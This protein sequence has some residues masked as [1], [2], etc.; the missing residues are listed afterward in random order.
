ML[1]SPQLTNVSE[2][3]RELMD[4]LGGDPDELLQL[5]TDW[6]TDAGELLQFLTDFMDQ[7][8]LVVEEDELRAMV[9]R[10]V[11]E[12]YVRELVVLGYDQPTIV[13]LAL[14]NATY[15]ELPISN[16]E[17]LNVVKAVYW[18]RLAEEAD[19]PE[20]TDVDRLRLAFEALDASGIIARENFTCCQ[21]CGFAEIGDEV[22]EDTRP[23]GFV[24][25]HQQDT[26]A[27]ACGGGLYLSYGVFDEFDSERV[28][29]IG[30]H[31]VR[32]LA[33]Q[34][35]DV[36]WDGSVMHRILVRLDWQARVSAL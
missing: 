32:A 22:P 27:A 36:E 3:L 12:A 25:F 28:T 7:N 21:T 26:Y 29:A 30:E 6:G 23:D 17:T 18:E 31:V 16:D 34:G 4:E 15:E 14:D 35:L 10:S 19:W 2:H 20:V 24:F 33:G 9:V 8:G 13:Q 1:D 11:T 5:L